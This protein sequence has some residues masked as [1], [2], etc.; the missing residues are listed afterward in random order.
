M[1]DRSF[2]F[3]RDLARREIVRV[4]VRGNCMAPLLRDGELVSVRRQFGYFPGDLV[5]FR[6]ATGGL[7]AHR[8]LGVRPF[9]GR[10][11]AVTKGDH[12]DAHDAPLPFDSII[13]RVAD[14]AVAPSRRVGAILSL[15]R[16]AVRRVM[17]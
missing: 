11:A 2:E 6:L 9:R 10:I 5:V 1:D 17:R 13:G 16:L 4:R 7:A 8:L 12:C 3:L 15:V 14:R